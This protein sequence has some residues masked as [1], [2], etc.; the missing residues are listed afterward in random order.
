MRSIASLILI[1]FLSVIGSCDQPPATAPAPSPSPAPR[2]LTADKEVLNH[3]DPAGD[4][5]KFWEKGDRRFV[6]MMN[7]GF[8]LPGIA[9]DLRPTLEKE[10]G[11]KMIDGITDIVNDTYPLWLHRAAQSYAEQYNQLLLERLR[12]EGKF[13]SP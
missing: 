5:A 6:G 11:I 7:V 2:T 9:S 10:F 12:S 3:N 4:F 13:P 1:A 8:S